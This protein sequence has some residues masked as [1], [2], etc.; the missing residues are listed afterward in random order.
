MSSCTCPADV[1]ALLRAHLEGADQSCPQ[2]APNADPSPGDD[3][4]L[5]SDAL[6]QTL[7]AKLGGTNKGATL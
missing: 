2:H 3:L 7:A 5:N 1:A 6:T 4:A